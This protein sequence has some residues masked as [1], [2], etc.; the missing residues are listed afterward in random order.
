MSEHVISLMEIVKAE[1]CARICFT[2]RIRSEIQ[3]VIESR[4][5]H[6]NGDDWDPMGFSWEWNYDQPWDGNGTGIKT[7]EWEKSLHIVN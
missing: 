1:S 7:W 5:V 6:G 3:A 2:C 4:D